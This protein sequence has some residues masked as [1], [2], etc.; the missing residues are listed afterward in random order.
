MG[1]RA[2]LLGLTLTA[3]DINTA[4][5]AGIDVKGELEI[6]ELKLSEAIASLNTLVTNVFTPA[7]DSGNAATINT[8]IT[9]LS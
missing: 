1:V 8:Q 4:E 6:I 2:T 3:G 9:N 7:G 5:A